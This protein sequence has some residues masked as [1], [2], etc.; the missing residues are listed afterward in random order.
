MYSHFTD[1]NTDS[2]ERNGFS[3]VTYPT[4]LVISP[5]TRSFIHSSV[6]GQAVYLCWAQNGGKIDKTPS[7][8]SGISALQGRQTVN[9]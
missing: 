6:M 7:S 8:L 2:P 9:K 3:D 5:Q 4:N 1:E